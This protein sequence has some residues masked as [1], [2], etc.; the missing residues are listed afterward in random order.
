MPLFYRYRYVISWSLTLLVAG[1]LPLIS[2]RH[3]RPIQPRYDD[4]VTAVAL[5]A[6]EPVAEPQ[7]L[8]EPEPE[9][10]IPPSEAI[11]EQPDALPA[12]KPAPKPKPKPRPVAKAE[13]KPTPVSPVASASHSTAAPVS[14]DPTKNTP[15]PAPTAAPAPAAPRPNGHAE[16]GLYLQALRHELAQYKRYPTGRQAS[17]EQP[18]GSVEIWLD[19]D[20]SGRVLSSGI[21]NKASSMLLNRA[22]TSTLQ[23]ITHVQP[24]PADAFD[25]QASKRFTATFD[26][27]AP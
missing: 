14:A 19:I 20:R 10:N 5:V 11:V 23:S 1:C 26:Y 12:P 24:F 13:R 27:Q 17:L 18:Q 6:P 21:A 4:T 22:A 8:S 2:Q 9:P 7:P 25:G 3:V 15:I 16:E